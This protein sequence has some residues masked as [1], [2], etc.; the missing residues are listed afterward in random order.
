M[1]DLGNEFILGSYS[2]TN[3]Y[4]YKDGKPQWKKSIKGDPRMMVKS[5]GG[6]I[7]VT[8]NEMNFIDVNGK[9]L[10]KRDV[11]IS[12]NKDDQIIELREDKG[13]IY[14]I[15][16]TY[17]NIVNKDTGE[18]IWKKNLKLEEKK[19][20]FFTYNEQSGEY[21]VYNDEKLYRYGGNTNERPEEF[22]KI[23]I[24]K[25]K[26]VDNIEKR[27][28]GY[29][30]TG[31]GEIVL[32]DN[33]GKIKYQK[34][35]QEPGAGIRRWSR[36]GLQALQT[37]AQLATSTVEA[38]GQTSGLF[39]DKKGRDDANEIATNVFLL[40]QKMSTRY[41]ASRSLKDYKF[42][43]TKD[44]DNKVLVKVNKDTGN[45]DNKFLFHDNKPK[46]SLDDYEKIIYY[47][48]GSEVDVFKY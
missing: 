41:N 13:K 4:S 19:P 29:L 42:Y 27:D 5:D 44:G 31:L 15:T 40:D 21:I 38:N 36:V 28:S 3:L 32:V 37:G 23:N 8:K 47:A 48:N 35:Y 24:K 9:E 17:A 33:G 1:E 18:K 46:Y 2:G 45:E 30:I 34:V 26:E 16:S 6:Y 14:Y 20:T 22:A 12:D 39:L 43:F 25:E 7:F 11:E 10:W